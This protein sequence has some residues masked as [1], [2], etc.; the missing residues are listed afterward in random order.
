V[1]STSGDDDMTELPVIRGDAWFDTH[2]KPFVLRVEYPLTLEEMVAALY[3]VVD[4]ADIASD[5]DLCGSVAVTLS[6]EGLP[7][8]SDRVQKIRRAERAGSIESVPFLATCR[9]RVTA[10]LQQVP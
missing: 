4:H 7:G 6:L 3:G 2:A 1:M 8:L 10:L 9:Q 5:E